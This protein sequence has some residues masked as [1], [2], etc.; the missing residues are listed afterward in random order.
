MFNFNKYDQKFWEEL[1]TLLRDHRIVINR[2]KGTKHPKFPDFIYPVNYGYLEDTRSMDGGGIDIWV[3]TENPKKLDSILCTIDTLKKVSDY[4]NLSNAEWFYMID[5]DNRTEQQL[6]KDYERILEV[7]QLV[8]VSRPGNYDEK[9][10]KKYENK[11]IVAETPKIDISSTMIR[12][13][14]KENRHWKSLVTPF[15]YRYIITHN[16]YKQIFTKN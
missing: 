2:P 10:I 15:V 7:A 8:V 12:K 4:E 3:G 13:L 5:F 14:I 9:I 11:L 16:L 6:W 1:D